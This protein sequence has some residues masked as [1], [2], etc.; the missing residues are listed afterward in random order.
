MAGDSNVH[1]HELSGLPPELAERIREEA[2]ENDEIY[3]RR[4]ADTLDLSRVH[5][6]HSEMVDWAIKQMGN[7]KGARILDVGIGDGLTSVLMA[8]AGA[9]V[10]G[11]EVSSVALARAETL[12]Q[13]Y[14]VG[15]NLQEMPGEDLRFEKDTFDGILCLSAYHHMDQKRAAFEF[16]RVLRRG[17]R[18]VMI[19]PF[20]SNP[21]AWL[22][23]R[24]GQI[25][26]REA[27]SRETPLRVRDLRFLREHFD[28]V[29]WRGMYFLSVGLIGL[30]RIW[31]NPHPSIFRFTESAFK[32]TSPFDSLVLRVP[33][34][35]RV[36]WKIAVVA[37]R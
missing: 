18:L 19:D 35:Q 9:Q 4:S 13:R 2:A 3:R 12:A 7:L 37:Q 32:W 28:K 6:F 24:I 22:Y 29:D 8:L 33:G 26:S 36:A 1:D 21:P 17:G 34:L 27:T 16:G 11:I 5:Y 15:L 25:F 23:R 31:K 30:E 10:T 20:A 14:N